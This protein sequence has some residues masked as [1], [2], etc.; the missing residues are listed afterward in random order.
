MSLGDFAAAAAD[1]AVVDDD[2]L[3]AEEEEE[4]FIRPLSQRAS[5]SP[6]LFGSTRGFDRH[7][8]SQI[9]N[10]EPDVM[11]LFL[12]LCKHMKQIF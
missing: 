1:P 11:D 7:Q 4:V 6:Q 9:C 3:E 12:I 5:E 10:I 2:D 8:L